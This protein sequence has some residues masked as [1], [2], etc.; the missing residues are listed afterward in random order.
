MIDFNR[1]INVAEKGLPKDDKE[2]FRFN[3][4][5]HMQEFLEDDEIVILVCRQLTNSESSKE[6]NKKRAASEREMMKAVKEIAKS[7]F[8]KK[9]DELSEE[10]RLEVAKSYAE[11]M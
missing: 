11:K 10:E 1:R 3:S 4:L 2:N 5:E 6:S 7:K 9:F 8:N